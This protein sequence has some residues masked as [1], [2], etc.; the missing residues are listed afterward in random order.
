VTAATWALA[1][2]VLAGSFLLSLG[3]VAAAL[4]LSD[5]AEL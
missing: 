5:K 4:I 3:L 1:G 2:A